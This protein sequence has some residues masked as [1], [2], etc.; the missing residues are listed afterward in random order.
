MSVTATAPGKLFVL[1]E[2]AALKG[3]PALLMAVNRRVQ[4]ERLQR[5]EAGWEIHEEPDARVSIISIEELSGA[6]VEGTLAAAAARTLVEAGFSLPPRVLLRADRTALV[7]GYG[8]PLG[9]G[10]SAATAAAYVAVLAP[11][12]DNN[13]MVSLAVAAHRRFQGGVGS[14]YD[15]ACCC[16]GGLV[17]VSS[18]GGRLTRVGEE[19]RPAP[20]PSTTSGMLPESLVLLVGRGKSIA[21]TS[22]ILSRLDGIQRENPLIGPLIQELGAASEA[23]C[24]A[25]RSGQDRQLVEAMRCFC[26]IEAELGELSGLK[27]VPQAVGMIANQLERLGGACKPSGAGCDLVVALVPR[28][29]R[30][31]ACALMTR[32]GWTPLELA[33]DPVGIQVSREAPP[34]AAEHR[35]TRG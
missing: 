19:C 2:F 18:Q 25:V 30:R 29:A 1:G 23:G 21:S 28:D 9:L 20:P 6:P 24:S 26:A 22:V 12:L 31:S 8:Q 7:D 15:V 17:E 13:T 35:L 33:C 4:I 5:T 32:A 34:G 27:L 3:A 14:G 10:S 11:D 16:A